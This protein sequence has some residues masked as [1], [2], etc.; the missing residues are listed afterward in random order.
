VLVDYY[1]STVPLNQVASIAVADAT[2]LTAQP[3]DSSQ[4]N[5]IEKA[6][7]ASGLGLNPSNDGKLIRIPIPPLTEDRRKDL[8]KKAH[9]HAEKCRNSVRQARREA[10]DKLKQLEKEKEISQDE[11]RRGH[12]E[13]QRLHDHYIAEVASTLQNKEADI[14]AL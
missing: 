9:E 11:E 14:L 13:V 10:N 6:I 12:D 2:L 3:Y 4:I 5:A 8:V 1:G 7:H